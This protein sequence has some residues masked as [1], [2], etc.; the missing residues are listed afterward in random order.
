MD[1]IQEIAQKIRESN[2]ELGAI[3]SPK[4]DKARKQK[5]EALS[6]NTGKMYFINDKG[7]ICRQKTNND[8]TIAIPLCNFNA[9]IIEEIIKDDGAE[10]TTNFLIEGYTEDGRTLPKTE[11]PASKY[12]NMN[13]V[14]EAWGT[15]AIVYAGQGIRDHLRV[16]IQLLSGDVPRR[17]IYTHTGWREIDGKW[18]YLHAGGA[19]GGNKN[20]EVMLED[21][22]SFYCLPEPPEGEELQKSILASFR[23][24]DIAPKRITYPLLASVYRAPLGDIDLSVFLAGPTGSQKSELTAMALAH[25]GRSFNARNLPG[26]WA[27]TANALEKMAFAIKDAI[28]V[29]DDFCPGGTNVDIQRLHKEADRLLRGQ[30]NKSGRIRL[31]ADGQLQPVYYPR[32]LILTSG[33]DIPHGQSLNARLVILEVHRGDVDLNLLS[34]V[35]K[36]AA[37]GLLAQ[38]MAG[39]IQWLVPRYET[40][41]QSINSKKIEVRNELRKLSFKHDRAPDNIASLTIGFDFFLEYAKSAHVLDE[42]T[43]EEIRKDFMQTMS[44]VLEA[45]NEY[46]ESEEPA[47]RFISLL[48][49][50]ISSGHAYLADEKE[51]GIPEEP[52]M[53]GW[54]KVG[55]DWVS[56]GERI[57]WTDGTNVFLEPDTAYAVCQRIARE[58]GTSIP[59]RQQTLWKH[60]LQKNII[61]AHDEGRSTMRKNIMGQRKRVINILVDTISPK[62]G[63][64]GPFG[65]EPHE[66]A[67]SEAQ[68]MDRFFKKEP[69]SVQKIGPENHEVE[70]WTELQDRFL[71]KNQKSVPKMKPENRMNSGTGPMGPNGPQIQDIGTHIFSDETELPL[72]GGEI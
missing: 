7:Q 58:Q 9:K 66:I 6:E 33:E 44:E 72:K 69:K 49:A 51:G 32:G 39:Y 64:I 55:Y 31:R 35:Q 11:V 10:K 15:K 53:F 46:Q 38:S 50:A 56:Q 29:V 28:F 18:V 26:N 40:I 57:G 61:A 2:I 16:A 12:P 22:L 3:V 20:V 54:K 63:P 24:L 30:G 19:I 4:L 52:Y 45:Q 60:L 36:D 8:G 42:K 1:K 65:P 71:E 34:Q 13:W 14:T 62:S 41:K 68:K 47:T 48:Q 27:S 70:N 43:A 23:L 59:V 17:I 21:N 37:D 67:P 5:K 25:W